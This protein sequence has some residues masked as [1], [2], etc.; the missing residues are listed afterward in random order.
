[1]WTN[2][3]LTEITLYAQ[4]KVKDYSITYN[5]NGGSGSMEPTEGAVGS[6]VMV[7]YNI[8][9]KAGKAFNG[10]NTKADGSGTP[11]TE[12]QQITLNSNMTLYA[13]W[14]DA[15]TY[16]IKD[17]S[18]DKTNK[19]IDL[20]GLKTSV[21]DYKKKFTLGT[22]VTIEVD[23]GTKPYVYTGSKTRIYRNGTL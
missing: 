21:A 17:Y 23:I 13:Q 10:W 1:M 20:I 16:S 12:G 5:A 15:F 22:G 6:T 14:V 11:Y 18:E 4:W 7:K 8:F 2:A 9:I 3:D 19:Y